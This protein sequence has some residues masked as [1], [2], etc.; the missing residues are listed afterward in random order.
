MSKKINNS[1]AMPNSRF[2]EQIIEST[3]SDQLERLKHNVR[4]RTKKS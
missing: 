2:I 3:N 4:I 1:P